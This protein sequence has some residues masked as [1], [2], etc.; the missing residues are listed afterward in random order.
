[1]RFLAAA[2]QSHPALDISNGH[3]APVEHRP[4]A[5]ERRNKSAAAQQ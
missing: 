5:P 3:P 1:V 4:E 2:L